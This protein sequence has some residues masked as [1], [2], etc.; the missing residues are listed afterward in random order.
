VIALIE[1]NSKTGLRQAVDQVPYYHYQS[2]LS[3]T[4]KW[5]RR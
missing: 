4:P 5:W 1:G 3:F 2:V